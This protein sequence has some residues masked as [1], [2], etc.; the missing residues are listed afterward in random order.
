MEFQGAASSKAGLAFAGLLMLALISSALLVP[1]VATPPAGAAPGETADG[2]VLPCKRKLTMTA[3][4]RTGGK[5]RFEGVADAS[6][7]GKL[8]R[9]YEIEDDELVATTR[10]RRDGTWWANSTTPGQG[11]TW[12]T[13]FVAEAGSAQSRWRRL[14][15]AV[16]IRGRKPV[17][18]S[19]SSGRDSTRTRVQVKVSGDS[20]DLLVVGVQTG[21]SR[22]EVEQKFKLKTNKVG[23]ATISLAR[24]A[25]GEPYAIY[26]ASTENGWK[27]SPP[28]VVKP[29]AQD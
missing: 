1:A 24:P 29:S 17:V 22:Y 21:C 19:S 11:Y 26:R 20:P 13:K 27:I 14:G 15:Q 4:Y 3:V 16:A 23:V 2:G 6:L 10:V 5:I 28:I 25:A 12:L 8:V 7:R 18:T 9:V